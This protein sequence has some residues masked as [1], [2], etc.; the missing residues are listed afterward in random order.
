MSDEELS[1]QFK[2]QMNTAHTIAVLPEWPHITELN[3]DVNNLK[4][5]LATLMQSLEVETWEATAE[6]AFALVES[7]IGLVIE[8]EESHMAVRARLVENRMGHG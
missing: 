6:A 2:L 1:E 5:L 7:N 4:F 3:R 8:R